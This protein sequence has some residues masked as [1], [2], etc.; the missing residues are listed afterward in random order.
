M[1]RK[2]SSKKSKHRRKS[3]NRRKSRRRRKSKN[4]KRYFGNTQSSDII[5]QKHQISETYKLITNEQHGILYW[6][7]MGAGKTVAGLTLILN[8]PDRKIN[9]VCPKDIIFVWENELRRIPQIVQEIKFYTYENSK[10]LLSRE[11]FE[12]EIIE[13]LMKPNILSE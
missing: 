9:I 7:Q 10:L 1:R 3:K 6:W 5:L 13:Y 2:K 8:Y 11:T 12:S 4:R